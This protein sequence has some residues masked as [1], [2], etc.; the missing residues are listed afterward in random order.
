MINTLLL[1]GATGDLA[2]RLLFPALASLHSAG[3]LPEGFRLVGTGRQEW[4]NH[5]FRQHMANTLERH[6]PNLA[7]EHRDALI[8]ASSYASADATDPEEIRKLV[9]L[10][11][12]E[13]GSAIAVYL[14]LP[15]GLFS[16]TIS[17]IRTA[18]LP[19]DSRIVVEKPFGEDIEGAQK[20]N[21]LLDE[22]SDTSAY[23]VDHV[24]GMAPL[25]NLIGLRFANPWVDAIWNGNFIVQVDILWEE[26]LALEGRATFYDKAGALKDVLQNHMI[27]VLC[28]AAMDRPASVQANDVQDRKVE[29]LNAVRP[30]TGE[31]AV[32]HTQRG[33][34]TAGTQRNEDGTPGQHIP[35][36]VDEEGVDPKRDT[37]TFAE[38]VLRI[39]NDRWQGTKFVVRTGKALRERRK[40]I[41]LHFRQ[42]AQAPTIF[43]QKESMPTSW[44]I[45]IDGP[46]DMT[47]TAN[48]T[49]RATLEDVLPFELNS[50]SLGSDLPPYAWV[51]ADILSG[52]SARSV[53]G[54]EAEAAWRIVTPVLEGWSAGRVPMLDYQAGS[55]GPP[56]LKVSN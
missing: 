41:V 48:G 25:Q 17:A 40:E 55:P 11:S 44:R 24:L 56:R 4:D 49:P 46:M 53:R 26:T 10:A 32:T 43:G 42:N 1:F 38:I 18:G 23:R 20:L 12:G 2:S 3:Q 33:R 15:Q 47:L 22:V 13:N 14:A 45:G 34:Y 19:P 36:Y 7:H 54:D 37:E 9:S 6:A 52:E 27:Q 30:F 5:R 31:D 35:D 16:S 21:Q 8:A 29:L 51:L 50:P 28:Y 39:D